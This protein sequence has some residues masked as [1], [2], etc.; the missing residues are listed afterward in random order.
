M[1]F[2]ITD[3]GCYDLTNQKKNQATTETTQPSPKDSTTVPI[4]NMSSHLEKYIFTGLWY[5]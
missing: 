1:F 3:P 5:R 2:Y 4:K